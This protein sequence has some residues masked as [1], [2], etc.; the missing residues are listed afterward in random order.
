[1][2]I[3]PELISTP[4]IFKKALTFVS[5]I[6]LFSSYN[7]GHELFK[8]IFST[9]FYIGVAVNAR[10]FNSSDEKV[11]SLIANLFNSLSP[12]NVLTWE[13]IHPDLDRYDFK[14]GDEYVAL[15]ERMELLT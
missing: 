1:M 13:R 15:G 14:S 7:P 6:L 12:E 3:I 4:K 9:G 11:S 10:Q 5:L 2:P 8:D